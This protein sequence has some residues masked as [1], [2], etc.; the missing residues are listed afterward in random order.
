ML[1]S[2]PNNIDFML[3]EFTINKMERRAVLFYIPSLTDTK[4]IDEEIIKPLI[5]TDKE[6]TDV[7]SA[8]SVSS[9]RTETG[10]DKAVNGL[11]TGDT[12]LLVEGLRH[13]YMIKTAS[14]AGRSVEKPQNETTLFGPKESFIE[15]ADINISLIRKRIRSEDFT[16][17]KLTIGAR[18]H[19]EVFIIY[20]KELAS[21]KVLSEV[22]GRIGAISKDAVQNI[23][24]LAQHIEDRKRSLVPTVLQTERPDRAA[25]F[26]EDGYVIVVMNN[27]PFAL[28]APST[29]WSFYHSGDDHYLRFINGNFTRLLRILAMFITLFTPSAYI[30]ITNY[31]MEMLPTDLLLAIAGAREMVPFPAILELLMLELAF[32]LIREAGVRVPVPIGPTIGIVGA[33]I[34]GQAGVEANVVS[35][36]VVIVV[37]LS[38]LSSYAIGD[39]NLNYTIRITRFAFL[40][41]AGLMGIFGMVLCFMAALIYLT[42][43]KSFGVPYLAPLTPAY[44]SSGDTVF[45]RLLTNE[46]LRPGFTKTKDITKDT[47]RNK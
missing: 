10:I 45:R 17:E 28:V 46:I 22:K 43:L 3:R 5:M 40:I 8:M 6:I 35:P 37:A 18:S 29:F 42:S 36:I 4:L 13:G 11:N 25:S 12:L 44:K 16:V 2:F 14:A 7:P 26:I 32:E 19:N 27:S 41:A 30:A 21:E 23:S 15:K 38:G 39:V 34:L 31:H 9:I 1:Y 47:V 20:N 33:L 24:L